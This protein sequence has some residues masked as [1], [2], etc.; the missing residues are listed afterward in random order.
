[1]GRVL[2]NGDNRDVDLS[3]HEGLLY[4]GVFIA[5]FL[6][7]AIWESVRPR[8]TLQDRAERRWK[9]HGVLFV[10]QAVATGLILRGGPV[11]YALVISRRPNGLLS[12][13]VPAFLG[14]VVGI[15]ALD[16]VNY[17]V[18]RMF[19]SVGFLWR[20]HEIHH[21]DRDFDV[22]TAGR[23]HPLETLATAGAQ[24]VAIRIL[25]P[26]P[27]CVLAAVLMSLLENVFVHANCSLPASAE[28]LVRGLVVTPDLHR[29]HHSSDR[30]DFDRNFGQ[31]FSFWDRLFGTWK[32]PEAHGTSGTGVAEVEVG[33]TLAIRYL[34]TGPFQR[35]RGRALPI[36]PVAEK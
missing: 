12:S 4:W 2:P 22:S 30:A 8:A 18:H 6:G 13:R 31:L 10:I 25:A 7:V 32:Q 15:L 14:F 19:H 35:R 5:G 29:L 26:S 24:L 23:F 36:L 33:E 11:Y 16:L 27:E 28:R 17:A 3:Q 1:M 34:L 20:V 21:S 9:V